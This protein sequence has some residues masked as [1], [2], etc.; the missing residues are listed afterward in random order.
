MAS[1][2]APIEVQRDKVAQYTVLPTDDRSI[3]DR[4]DSGKDYVLRLKGLHSLPVWSEWNI[5]LN[6]IGAKA[7][8]T[9]R[10]H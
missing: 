8:A 4:S 2:V 1:A 7:M 5:K 6:G 10:W 3:N 9:Q